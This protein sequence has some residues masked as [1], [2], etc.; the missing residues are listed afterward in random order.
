MPPA[1]DISTP[2]SPAAKL[3][4]LGGE[5]ENVVWF[6]AITYLGRESFLV[7]KERIL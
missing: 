4:A 5:H 7:E 2:G 6:V 3:L 1:S